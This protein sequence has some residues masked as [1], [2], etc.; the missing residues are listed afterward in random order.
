MIKPSEEDILQI[1]T[2]EDP[3]FKGSMEHANTIL[4]SEIQEI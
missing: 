1:G 2:Y 3:G 4:D